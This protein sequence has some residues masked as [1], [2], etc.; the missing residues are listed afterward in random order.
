MQLDPAGYVTSTIQDPNDLHHLFR[1]LATRP[2]I[3]ESST[4][5]LAEMMGDP[6]QIQREA[7]DLDAMRIQRRDQMM[8]QVNARR[9]IDQNARQIVRTATKTIESL[10]PSGWDDEARG[11]FTEDV[12]NDVRRYARTNN[13]NTVDPRAVP[14]LVQHRLKL[15]GL[16]P[17][18]SA[19]TP[20]GGTPTPTGNKG[21]VAGQAPSPAQ[22]QQQSARRHSA[23]SAPPGAGS[24]VA[25]IP[26]APAYDPKAPGSP[27]QQAANY[28][29]T[30]IRRFQQRP[31]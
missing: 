25:A 29:R 5:W 22:L 12:L 23:A 2:G 26:K 16:A 21:P 19:N 18:N 14:G 10:A 31:S 30:M 6:G 8:G 17:R 1:Y 7:R 13:L 27:V 24:P 11:I 20:Q 9:E 4:D 3:L 28:A 15:M